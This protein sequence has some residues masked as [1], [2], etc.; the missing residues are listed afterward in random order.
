MSFLGKQLTNFSI[1]T[2]ILCARDEVPRYLT[3]SSSF[4]Q[5]RYKMLLILVLLI[6]MF[7]SALYAILS[8]IF[9]LLSTA[10]WLAVSADLPSAMPNSRRCRSCPE[11]AAVVEAGSAAPKSSRECANDSSRPCV[12]NSPRSFSSFV[13]NYDM[14][15]GRAPTSDDGQT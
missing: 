7:G 9:L 2:K 11:S 14:G 6:T 3:W 13:G 15:N 12:S 10:C 5:T 8:I 1:V 4:E